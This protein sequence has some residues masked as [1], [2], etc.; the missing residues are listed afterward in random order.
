[1]WDYQMCCVKLHQK[2]TTAWNRCHLKLN[3]AYIIQSSNIG[4]APIYSVPTVLSKQW[5][6][7][8]N[9]AGTVG[10]Q[11]GWTITTEQ[12]RRHLF[13]LGISIPGI[14]PGG[15][16]WGWQTGQMRT[17]ESC[18]KCLHS[19]RDELA[20]WRVNLC[21]IWKKNT[22]ANQS[23]LMTKRSIIKMD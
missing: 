10:N 12:S 17:K 15:N 14:W 9:S 23:L 13:C 22:E 7:I 2:C 5:T 18:P 1:M 21:K 19:R 16:E 6:V 8:L 4:A 3:S 20:V 11:Y